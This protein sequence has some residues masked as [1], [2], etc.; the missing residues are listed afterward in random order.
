MNGESL[1]TAMND[2]APALVQAAEKAR[3]RPVWR[4]WAAAAACLCLLLG[5]T[6]Y[7]LLRLDYFRTGCSAWAGTLTGGAYY[8]SVPHSGVWRYTPEDGSQKLVGA[9]WKDGWLAN[10]YGVY[11][12]RGRSLFV[13]VH[14]TGKTQ[15]LYHAPRHAARRIGLS[16][17]DDGSL[18]VTL[19]ERDRQHVTELLL[20]GQ[21]GALLQTLRAHADMEN[22]AWFPAGNRFF[23]LGS[24]T[25]E[26]CDRTCADGE[27][28]FTLTENGVSMLPE[29]QRVLPYP[30][31]LRQALLLQ[32]VSP[33]QPETEQTLLLLPDGAQLDGVPLSVQD[34]GVDGWLLYTHENRLWRLSLADGSRQALEADADYE[35]YSFV[36]DGTLLMTCVPWDEAQT[37]WQLVLDEDGAPSG[38]RLLCRDIR[39]N[40]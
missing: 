21:S 4:S 39:E 9:F 35:A 12:T 31:Q 11:Y 28:G 34:S 37:C 32:T 38:I 26:L 10:D 17:A 22:G 5:G 7:T 16:L 30:R 13:R 33:A 6:V 14:E 8:Y 20:D 24:R 18:Y 1:L 27:D 15:R 25:L 23:R 36:C 29:D 2:V 40:R 3:R 19:Y